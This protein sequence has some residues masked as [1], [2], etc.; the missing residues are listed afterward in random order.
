MGDEEHGPEGEGT[1]V[2]ELEYDYGGR[3][4]DDMGGL[5]LYFKDSPRVGID[6]AVANLTRN[7]ANDMA[8]RLKES[9]IAPYEE[10]PTI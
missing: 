8:R 9:G 6:I 2:N 3:W 7:Q 5:A 10:G 4:F 1:P